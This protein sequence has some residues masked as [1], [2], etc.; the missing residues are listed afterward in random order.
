MRSRGSILRK[1]VRPASRELHRD[2]SRPSGYNLF[3][4]LMQ[5]A[6]LQWAWALLKREV[7]LQSSRRIHPRLRERGRS[8]LASALACARLVPPAFASTQTTSGPRPL[9]CAPS[10]LRSPQNRSG[11]C[12]GGIARGSSR[13]LGVPS[14]PGT[15]VAHGGRDSPRGVGGDLVRPA[16][17]LGDGAHRALWSVGPSR[18]PA[19][20]VP[21]DHDD[22]LGHVREGARAHHGQG[23][24]NARPE[25]SARRR[26]AATPYRRPTTTTRTSAFCAPTAR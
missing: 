23:G 1:E 13:R 24:C 26:A 14:E 10:A 18:A 6:Q 20:R 12:R 21:V 8:K 22:R 15:D 2:G 9:G 11:P 5:D 25:L 3:R 4:E 16:S 7:A 19:A 17:D